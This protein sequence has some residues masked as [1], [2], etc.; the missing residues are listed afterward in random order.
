MRMS[1][2]ALGKLLDDNFLAA[3]NEEAVWEA[4]VAWMRVEE[5]R[6]RGLVAK[7]RFPLMEEGYLLSRVV[8]M[9][10]AEDAEFI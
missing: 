10:P 6:G 8:E 7:V 5:G 9:A 1:E 4:V 2:E 3:R